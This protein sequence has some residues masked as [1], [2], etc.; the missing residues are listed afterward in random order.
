MTF[1]SDDRN[2]LLDDTIAFVWF[3][4]IALAIGVPPMEFPL[5]VLV[6]RYVE[7]GRT[8]MPACRSVAV[9][10]AAGGLSPVS[11]R[12]SRGVGA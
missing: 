12:P 9:G 1:W 7:D 4:V 8:P 3:G 5:I 11:S 2:H 6:L 10:G